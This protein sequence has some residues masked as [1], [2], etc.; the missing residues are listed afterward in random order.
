MYRYGS[1]YKYMS[2]GERPQRQ[3]AR[4]FKNPASTTLLLLAIWGISVSEFVT[5]N[6]RL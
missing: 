4:I 5:F 1:D 3:R 6:N 2:A